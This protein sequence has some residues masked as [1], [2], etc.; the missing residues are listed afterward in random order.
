MR[1]SIKTYLVSLCLFSVL[2]LAGYMWQERGYQK[3]AIENSCAQYNPKTAAFEWKPALN[4]D[5]L[6]MPGI[7]LKGTAK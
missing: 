7:K 6:Q 1:I 3:M 5:D 4:L 2:T